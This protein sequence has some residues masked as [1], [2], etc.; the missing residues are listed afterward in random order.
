MASRTLMTA[1]GFLWGLVLGVG[2]GLLAVAIAAGVAWL[3]LFGDDPWP[4][5]AEWAILGF[6]LAVGLIVFLTCLALA[7]MVARRYDAP[8]EEGR[9]SAIARMLIVAALGAGALYLWAGYRNQA[10]FDRAAAGR[11][12][13]RA[14]LETLGASVHRIES[15]EI[16]WPGGGRDGRAMLDLAGWRSG[17]Y[18]LSWSVHDTAFQ[19]RLIGG[20]RTLDLESGAATVEVPLSAHGLAAAYR[21]LLSGPAP[22]VLVDDPMDFRVTLEPVLTVDEQAS[23]PEAERHN[24]E[25]GWSDLIDHGAA[26]FRARFRFLDGMLSWDD[27]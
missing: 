14:Y 26:G 24:L 25:R 16:D 5:W 20:E 23:L 9:R 3:F 6:G 12:Q 7:R 17:R 18:H 15:V 4:W 2:A 10:E 13:A 11:A 27:K 1:A 22:D 19:E 21:G 8:E